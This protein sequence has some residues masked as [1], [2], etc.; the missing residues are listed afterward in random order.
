MDESIVK[1]WE[2]HDEL[3]EHRLTAAREYGAQSV[4]AVIA[5]PCAAWDRPRAVETVKFEGKKN[6][7]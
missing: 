3:K 4:L 7:N 1:F 6:D 5:P 2:R